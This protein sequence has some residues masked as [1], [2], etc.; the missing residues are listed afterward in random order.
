MSKL[1]RIAR[2]IAAP[3]YA[4]EPDSDLKSPGDEW[5]DGQLLKPDQDIVAYVVRL[6]EDHWGTTAFDENVVENLERTPPRPLTEQ[7]LMAS[8]KGMGVSLWMDG[9]GEDPVWI[10]TDHP[11]FLS[12]LHEMETWSGASRRPTN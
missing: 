4:W 5:A 3:D 10:S 8:Y 7:E 6:N 2:R 12:Y 11:E 1:Q 9:E